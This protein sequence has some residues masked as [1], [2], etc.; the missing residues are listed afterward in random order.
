MRACTCDRR[1]AEFGDLTRWLD[2]LL[3]ANAR[4]VTAELLLALEYVP[5]ST[6]SLHC[7]HAHA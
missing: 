4:L 3:P 1:Y 5:A 7:M 6:I 2:S